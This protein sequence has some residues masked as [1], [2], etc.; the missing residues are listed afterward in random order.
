[1]IFDRGGTWREMVGARKMA[2][3]VVIDNPNAHPVQ[4][5]VYTN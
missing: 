3:T 4:Y 5:T 2:V 1:M